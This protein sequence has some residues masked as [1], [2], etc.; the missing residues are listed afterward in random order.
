MLRQQAQ[1]QALLLHA[2]HVPIVA[3]DGLQAQKRFG[4]NELAADE[5]RPLKMLS[6]LVHSTRGRAP[7]RC[8]ASELGMVPLSWLMDGHAAISHA[9]GHP[10]LLVHLQAHPSGSWL[11][12]SLMTCWSRCAPLPQSMGSFM[13][14]LTGTC[15]AYCAVPA[16]HQCRQIVGHQ[17]KERTASLSFDGCL[18]ILIVAAV[19]DFG[20]AVINGERGAR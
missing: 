14:Q 2:C 8:T 9:R 19:V 13:W 4:R 11:L 20:I 17:A 12:N 10:V 18:Q 15:D 6:A 16:R 1:A 3:P 5:G 7:I